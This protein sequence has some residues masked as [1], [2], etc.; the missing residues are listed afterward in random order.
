M[1]C[2]GLPPQLYAHTADRIDF[3]AL[4]D[5]RAAVIGGAASAFDA[6]ATALDLVLGPE[7]ELG[8]GLDMA[9]FLLHLRSLWKRRIARSYGEES[10]T[11]AIG[12][13]WRESQPSV[14]DRARSSGPSRSLAC[15]GG[16]TWAW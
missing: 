5:K 3:V 6:A 2:D 4:R 11:R 14:P 16:A 9:L 1:L 13:P 8:R 7:R 15:A 12:R 10:S